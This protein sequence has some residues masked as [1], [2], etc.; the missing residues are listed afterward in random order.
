MDKPRNSVDDPYFRTPLQ[1]RINGP[2]VHTFNP[3]TP[4]ELDSIEADRELL[5]RHRRERE[6]IEHRRMLREQ[7]K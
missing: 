3:A 7:E 2:L 5:E 4:A 1:D 6:E